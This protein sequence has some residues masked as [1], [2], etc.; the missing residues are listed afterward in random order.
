M[1]RP[2]QA[3]MSNVLLME[4]QEISAE[5]NV[6]RELCGKTQVWTDLADVFLWEHLVAV[7]V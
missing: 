3:A 6:K 5:S 1:D 4:R 7:V 2:G